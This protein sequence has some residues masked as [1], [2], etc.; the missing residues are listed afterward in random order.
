MKTLYKNSCHIAATI[1]GTL[2]L[3][4]GGAAALTQDTLC[5][6][7]SVTMTPY[8]DMGRFVVTPTKVTYFVHSADDLGRFVVNRHSAVFVSA[9]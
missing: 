8:K 4:A 3:S 9:A 6:T 2:V 5:E 7:Q 1:V